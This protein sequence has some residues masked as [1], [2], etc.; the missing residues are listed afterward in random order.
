MIA[1]LNSVRTRKLVPPADARKRPPR[2]W[3][4]GL[5][6]PSRVTS[7]RDST[8]TA[9]VLISILIVVMLISMVALSLLFRMRAEEKA[10]TAGMGGEQAWA[11][12]MGG[13]RHAIN[14]LENSS[15]PQDWRDNPSIFKNQFVYDDGAQRWYFSVYSPGADEA[16]TIRYGLSDEA[17]KLNVNH[18]SEESLTAIPLLDESMAQAL[19][20][21]VDEDSQAQPEGAEQP[22]YDTLEKPYAIHNAPLKT[23]DELLMVRGFTPALFYGEDANQN[24]RLDTNEDDGDISFPPDNSNGELARGLRQL[25]TVA[26]YDLNLDSTDSERIDVNDPEASLSDEPFPED[27]LK[28]FETARRNQLTITNICDLVEATWTMKDEENQN[29]EYPSGI[30]EESLPLALDRLT[31]TNAYHL[32][33]LININSASARV[34]ATVPGIDDAMASEIIGARDAIPPDEQNNIAWL[35]TEKIVDPEEFRA[36]GRHLTARGHQFS[37]RA[38][39][40]SNQGQYRI[41]EAIVDLAG[42]RPRIIYLRDISRFGLPFEIDLPET[43]MTEDSSAVLESREL[44][45]HQYSPQSSIPVEQHRTRLAATAHINSN[46]SVLYNLPLPKG[47]DRGEGKQSIR[48]HVDIVSIQR[49]LYP[50]PGRLA[51]FVR[52]SFGVTFTEEHEI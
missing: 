44:S 40:Y 6:S 8:H 10:A 35:Y 32:H 34:L 22:F 38:A 37:L 1:P 12:A 33:G 45:H 43:G 48:V 41:I 23:L 36:I 5:A 52:T 15:S 27:T 7:K 46:S 50:V 28:F 3:R 24:F 11:A 21:F 18:A 51:E 16:A 17:G 26:S 42:D 47:E 31:H 9:F 4:D 29:R 2:N 19:I 39:G 13:V 49:P 14:I 20:D 30:D 25:L